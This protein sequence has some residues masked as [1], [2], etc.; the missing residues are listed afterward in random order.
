MKKV[1]LT[2]DGKEIT[3]KEGMTILEAAKTVP[4][5]DIP[6]LCYSDKLKPRGSCRL[7]MVE[8]TRGK[9]KKLVASCVYPVEEGLLVET[10]TE[11]VMKIRRMLIEL[12]WPSTQHL[13][14]EYG[15]TESRFALEQDDCNL[16]GM[17]ARYCAEVKKK[18][19]VYF[20]GRGVNRKIA[21]VEGKIDE[22]ISCEECFNLCSGGYIM[23]E[24]VKLGH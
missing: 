11:K 7:C 24:M 4:E 9:R 16:C 5:I 2:I 21:F 14:E 3:C 17:C 12:L 23:N 10:R 19:V 20:K 18:N 6:T 13:A 15:I 8:I 22:C 1:T